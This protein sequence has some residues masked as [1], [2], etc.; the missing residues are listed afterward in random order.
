MELNVT[1]FLRYIS[2]KIAECDVL[3]N[4]IELHRDHIKQYFIKLPT[5]QITDGKWTKILLALYSTEVELMWNELVS[6]ELMCKV[7][8][9]GL[10][11]RYKIYSIFTYQKYNTK[12]SSMCKLSLYDEHFIQFNSTTQHENSMKNNTPIN[13]VQ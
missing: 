7:L 4:F 2:I 11:L 9:Y 8:F 5:K 13:S 6:H 12:C 10:V 3:Y 1:P